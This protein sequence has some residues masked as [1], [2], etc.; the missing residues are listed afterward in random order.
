MKFE[1]MVVSLLVAI[2]DRL[3]FPNNVSILRDRENQIL[4]SNAS[5]W[6]ST[7]IYKTLSPEEYEHLEQGQPFRDER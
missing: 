2:L 5:A 4:M 6:A 7:Q 1:S 3:F